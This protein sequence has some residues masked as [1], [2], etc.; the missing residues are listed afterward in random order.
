MVLT[1]LSRGLTVPQAKAAKKKWRDQ[2]TTKEEAK[3]WVEGTLARLI[4]LRESSGTG[5]APPSQVV[6]IKTAE[7]DEWAGT[8]FG[9]I[10]CDKPGYRALFDREPT[11][12]EMTF[13]R[14]PKLGMREE[15]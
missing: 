7:S 1:K 4:A 8:E 9:N 15:T 11:I 14:L 13:H 5:R 2:C 10:F 3:I 12:D 6:T